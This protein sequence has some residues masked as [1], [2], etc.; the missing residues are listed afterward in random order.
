MLK[1]KPPSTLL[2]PFIHVHGLGCCFCSERRA[3]V[4][5][6]TVCLF[7]QTRKNIANAINKPAQR[8]TEE[9]EKENQKCFWALRGL[10]NERTLGSSSGEKGKGVSK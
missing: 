8:N 4:C 5:V 10:D 9:K 6:S 2:L 3:L 1:V 7:V